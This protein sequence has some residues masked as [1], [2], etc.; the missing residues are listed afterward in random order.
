MKKSF[1]FLNAVLDSITEHIAVI[2]EDGIIVYVNRSWKNFARNNNC[3][4]ETQWENI[5]YLHVCQGAAQNG[6]EFGLAAT[7]GIEAVIHK[8]KDSFY[9]EYPCHG[10]KEER[11]FMMRVVPFSIENKN[12]FIISHQNITERKLAEEEVC[13]L[14]QIDGLTSIA[15]RRTFNQFIHDSY[16]RFMRIEQPITLLMIDLDHFK[17]LNDTYGHQV[18]DHCLIEAAKVFKQYANRADD[19]CARYGGEEFAIVLGATT[20]EQAIPLAKKILE[21]IRNLKIPNKNA[22]TA[23]YLTASIGIA[24]LVPPRNSTELVLIQR[25]DEKLYLAKKNGRDRVEF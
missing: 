12:Y 24:E 18:G 10:P 2:N 16:R 20:K 23:E 1:E 13:E 6:D 8:R 22:P 9:F 7:E 25:A 5:N 11:W 14:A 3:S 4:I 19:L 15:N 21:K 17:I